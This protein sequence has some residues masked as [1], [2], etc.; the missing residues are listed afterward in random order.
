MQRQITRTKRHS[1]FADVVK[2]RREE[3]KAHK[4]MYLAGRDEHVERMKAINQQRRETNKANIERHKQQ[5]MLGHINSRER[6]NEML[7]QGIARK[8]DEIKLHQEMRNKEAAVIYTER[9]QVQQ[10][11]QLDREI[12]H[13]AVAKAH[14]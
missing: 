14:H 11:L 6:M 5:I 12:Y 1:E 8:N 9:K 10:K 2:A 13:V 7:R 3:D 4:Y